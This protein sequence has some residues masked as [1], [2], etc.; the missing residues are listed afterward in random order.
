MK[1]LNQIVLTGFVSSCMLLAVTAVK[2]D[3]DIVGTVTLDTESGVYPGL[4]GGEFTAFTSQNFAQNYYGYGSVGTGLNDAVYNSG[5][6]VNGTTTGFETFCLET[7]VDFNPGATYSYSLG[8][9]TQPLSGVGKGSDMSLT[10]GAAWLYQEFATGGF[11]ATQFN[12][13]QGTTR[14]GDDNLLQAAIWA[15]Q[16]GQTYSSY[17]SGDSGNE[18]YTD[19]INA[20]GLNVATNAYTGSSVEVLQMW[21]LKDG[22]YTAAQNQLVYVPDVAE[23]ASLLGIGLAGIVLLQLKGRK[24]AKQLCD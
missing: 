3:P 19:A 13:A 21:T 18:F 2:A 17:P 9:T 1:L 16:G 6:A 5:S 12:Y 22:K 11:T 24:T 10:A 4:G 14:K 7:G 20:L 15:F 8:E 23:T